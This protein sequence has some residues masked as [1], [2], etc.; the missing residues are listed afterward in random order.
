MASEDRAMA[1]EPIRPYPMNAP[2][3][4]YVEN[5]CCIACEAPYHEACD[6]MAHDEEGGHCY[7]RRQPE[8]PEEVE[9]AIMACRVSCVRAVRYSGDDPEI[10]R[11]FRDL[12]SID[13]CDVVAS[14]WR[15]AVIR[16][17][18]WASLSLKEKLRM[19]RRAVN[20]KRRSP[21]E[22]GPHPLFDRELDG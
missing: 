14:E 2:G 5:N 7:F 6:L 9:R 20:G 11:R 21:P 18:N 8:T 13:S 16:D 17:K 1:A 10:L 12:R 19:A 4:F 15:S 3:P 22:S